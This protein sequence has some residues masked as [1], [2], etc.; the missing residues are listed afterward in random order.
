MLEDVV[1]GQEQ[2]GLYTRLLKGFFRYIKNGILVVGRWIRWTA[3][4]IQRNIHLIDICHRKLSFL[5]RQCSVTCTGSAVIPWI[6]L[7][8]ASYGAFSLAFRSRSITVPALLVLEALRLDGAELFYWLLATRSFLPALE[9]F[10]VCWNPVFHPPMSLLWPHWWLMVT[11]LCDTW[12]CLC[13][14][15]AE[16]AGLSFL[17]TLPSAQH[18]S[19]MT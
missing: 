5:N 6:V 14:T 7:H 4:L 16:G 18:A 2:T 8:T 13:L 1:W 15:S 10:P 17:A 11:L 9:K 19:D 3:V 12:H